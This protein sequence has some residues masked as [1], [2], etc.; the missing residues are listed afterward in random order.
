VVPLFKTEPI[1]LTAITLI[2]RL[3]KLKGSYWKRLCSLS[4]DIPDDMNG[5]RKKEL[6]Q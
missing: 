4:R 3:E 2:S 5:G 6:C 1:P